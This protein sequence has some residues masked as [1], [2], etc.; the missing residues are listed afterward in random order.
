[1]ACVLIATL[2]ESLVTYQMMSTSGL[3]ALALRPLVL[4]VVHA[5][6][7]VLHH[8]VH[9]LQHVDVLLLEHDQLHRSTACGASM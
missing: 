5:A 9:V 7:H 1:M 6:A 4:V 2:V 8:V 3:S